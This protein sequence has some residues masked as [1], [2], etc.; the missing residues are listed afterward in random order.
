MTS[1]TPIEVVA[2]AIE[3]GGRYLLGRRP[4][5]GAPRSG[6]WEFPGGKVDADESHA[7]ALARE[8]VEE[9]DVGVTVE[10]RLATVEHRYPDR[11]V[12]LHLYRCRVAGEPRATYHDEVGWF[13]VA[14]LAALEL[15]EADRDLLRWL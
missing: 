7:E 6:L 11:T 4:A 3:R 14:E 8:I 10:A 9:L 15:S 12:R 2:A 13:T 1:R 5:T